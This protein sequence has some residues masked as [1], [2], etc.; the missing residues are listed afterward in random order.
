MRRYF[1]LLTG[2]VATL[3]LLGGCDDRDSAKQDT[4]TEKQAIAAAPQTGR[5]GVGWHGV[6]ETRQSDWGFVQVAATTRGVLAAQSNAPGVD[7]PPADA[8]SA[9]R[10]ALMANMLPARASVR[11]EELVNRAAASAA[12]YNS[13]ERPRA[14]LATAPWNDET[15]LLW[16]EIPA[17]LATD[18]AAVGV[19]FDPR[20][21]AAFRALGD[22]TAL[23]LSTGASAGAPRRVAMIYELSLQP[24]GKA[25]GT[26]ANTQFALLHIGADAAAGSP[27]QDRPITAADAVGTIDNAPEVVRLAAAAAG[28]GELLRGD[29][30]MRDL[31]CNDVIA[32]AQSVRRPDPDGWRARLIALMYRAQPLID[33]PPGESGR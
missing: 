7:I 12:L 27:R 11:I 2:V 10:A 5:L 24:S 4:K 15:T 9:I 23:P 16:V 32:L 33:L 20:T 31:S 26:R 13:D 17:A 14:V 1:G 3:A 18:G 8:L 30:A 6:P 25:G 28:F 22:P 21:V 19:E 29:P